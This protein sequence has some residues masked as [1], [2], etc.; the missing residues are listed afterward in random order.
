M[1]IGLALM[2]VLAAMYTYV[3][4]KLSVLH[5]YVLDPTATG[6]DYFQFVELDL[7]AHSTFARIGKDLLLK[8]YIHKWYKTTQVPIP[9]S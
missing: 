9:Y 1:L 4:A 2:V 8:W 6:M 5:A 3:T 7:I